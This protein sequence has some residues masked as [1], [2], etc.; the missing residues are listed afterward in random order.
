MLVSPRI[1]VNT[2]VDTLQDVLVL[3][4]PEAMHVLCVGVY[5]RHFREAF[6][7]KRSIPTGHTYCY[8]VAV[9]VIKEGHENS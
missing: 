3:S 8:L 5:T 4:E 7:A 1:Q 2:E 6:T 9:S